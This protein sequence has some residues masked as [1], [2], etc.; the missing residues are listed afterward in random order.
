MKGGVGRSSR[1]AR[2]FVCS[3]VFRARQPNVLVDHRGIDASGQHGVDLSLPGSDREGIEEVLECE[4]FAAEQ[5]GGREVA[6]R[7]V[8]V[9]VAETF[10]AQIAPARGRVILGDDEDA[11]LRWLV[12]DRRQRTD[13]AAIGH[14]AQKEA[15]R[16]RQIR[17]VEQPLAKRRRQDIKVS[18]A[19]DG[20][21]R[22]R[23][24]RGP[25]RVVEREVEIGVKPGLDLLAAS[26]SQTLQAWHILALIACPLRA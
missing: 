24:E 10:A 22:G 16:R 1:R 19:G 7:A 25:A 13:D 21:M 14:I 18:V 20:A 5:D 9:D 3:S 17:K 11:A 26:S 2:I 12:R 8:G 4:P 23:G 6:R 15:V